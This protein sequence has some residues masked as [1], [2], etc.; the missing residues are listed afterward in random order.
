MFANDTNLFFSQQNIKAV[1]LELNKF[2]NGL[3]QT[4]Y[5]LIKIKVSINFST[6]FQ[7]K[8]SIPLTLPSCSIIDKEI[9]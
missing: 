9:K 7:K 1:S 6:K 8:I 5:P 2:L 4:N 3:T